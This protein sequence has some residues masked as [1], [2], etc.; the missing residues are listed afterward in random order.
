MAQQ[1]NA[2]AAYPRFVRTS[3]QTGTHL[4][5]VVCGRGQLST[6]RMIFTTSYRD[7]GRKPGVA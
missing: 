7:G 4:I 6:K 2:L 5:S 1:S 3:G